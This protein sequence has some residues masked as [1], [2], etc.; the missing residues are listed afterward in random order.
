MPARQYNPERAVYF[1]GLP[2]HVVRE[3][4]YNWVR[5]LG[6][7]R[8]LDLPNG[9]GNLHNKGYGYV[10][11]KKE[12]VAQSIIDKKKLYWKGHTITVSSYGDRRPEE[13]RIPYKDRIPPLNIHQENISNDIMM[14]LGKTNPGTPVTEI[15]ETD[16]AIR[17]RSSTSLSTS[18]E[19]WPTLKK[20]ATIKEINDTVVKFSKQNSNQ[21]IVPVSSSASLKDITTSS[22]ESRQ[23]YAE[24]ESFQESSE[25]E[26]Q[27]SQPYDIP[28]TQIG[29]TQIYMQQMAPVNNVYLDMNTV[30][31]MYKVL[32]D[33]MERINIDNGSNLSVNTHP[34]LVDLFFTEFF[35]ILSGN[36]TVQI[37]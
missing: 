31:M 10:H 4:V 20:T 19:S 18:V 7:I 2:K 12:K 6:W 21:T 34:D 11:F 37:C 27:F 1:N 24:D 29:N 17:S 28:Q 14:M 36:T 26:I 32:G 33:E 3:E 30:S 8:K 9:Y 5:S 13:E 16:S 22:C 35:R 23:S 15:S 25:Q